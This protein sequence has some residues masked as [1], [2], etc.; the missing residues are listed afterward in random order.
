MEIN[1][2]P[3]DV[4]RGLG[5][6]YT[7]FRCDGR[8]HWP[9]TSFNFCKCCGADWQ[10]HHRLVIQRANILDVSFRVWFGGR[11]QF[12]DDV[13][14]GYITLRVSTSIPFGFRFIE[15]T[16]RIS[17]LEYMRPSMRT[18]GLNLCIGIF[19]C[20]GSM[21]TPWIA[22]WLGS[23]QSYLLY[24]SLPIAIVPLFYFILPE[25]A[26]WLISKNDIEAAIVCYR[27]VARFNGKVLDNDTIESF[28]AHHR[29][30]MMKQ[31]SSTN[32]PGLL[33]LFRTPRLR[34]NTLILFFKS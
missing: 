26:Q 14:P 16:Y 18:F 10:W 5:G 33:G 9:F 25:S 31:G 4:L 21:V 28:R 11:Q 8:S 13:H 20:L 1:D 2:W 22:V 7:D 23:W 32:G 15:F 19:Y 3:V 24:T 29:N 27:R 30:Q 17:V 34:R 12:P 6:W